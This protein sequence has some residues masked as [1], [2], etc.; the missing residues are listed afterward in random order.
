MKNNIT[1]SAAKP[2]TLEEGSETISKE[3]T[4]DISS[5]SAMPLT[6]NAEGD[7]IVQNKNKENFIDKANKKFKRKSQTV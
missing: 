6:G 5:G 4:L 3:S 7:D 2:L 1:Q